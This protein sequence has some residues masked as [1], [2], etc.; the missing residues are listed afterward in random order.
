MTRRRP[1]RDSR[2]CVAEALEFR[3][4][5]SV[6]PDASGYFADESAPLDIDL[7]PGD[8]GVITL[9]DHT[10]DGYAPLD[11]LGNTFRF[12]GKTY[13][14][15]Q[16]LW[17]S[18]NGVI[19]FDAP[20]YTF[21]NADLGYAPYQPAVAP[22]WDE[23]ITYAHDL[24]QVIYRFDN[25]DADPEP[26][27]LVVEWNDVQH[28]YAYP[29]GNGVTFQAILQLNTG[30]T[31]GEITFNYP[32]LDTG[33]FYSE[34]NDATAGIKGE[35]FDYANRL[36]IHY[37]TNLP[38]Q[39]VGTGKAVTITNI[40]NEAPEV[41]IGP[42]GGGNYTVATNLVVQL[43][44][45]GT[46]DRE[47]PSYSL[48]YEWDL[49]NDG[50]FGEYAWWGGGGGQ[51]GFELGNFTEF[52]PRDLPIGPHPIVLR[53][54]DG[55]G[56]STTV[57]GTIDVTINHAPVPNAGPRIGEA[58]NV[59]VG[60][61]AQLDGTLT[62][63]PDGPYESLW[64][65]WNLDGDED[66]GE[67]WYLGGHGEEIGPFPVYLANELQ[68][69]DERTITLRVTDSAGNQAY[70]DAVVRV[71]ANQAPVADAGPVGGGTYKVAPGKYIFLD[72]NNSRDPDEWLDSWTAF[73]WDFDNDLVFG[74]YDTVHGSEIGSTPYFVPAPGDPVGTQYPVALQVTDAGG[75]TSTDTAVV[76]IVPN[77]PPVADAGP[78]NPNDI[79]WTQIGGQVYLNGG[80]STDFEDGY[81]EWPNFQWD[82]DNDGIFGE[83]WYNGGFPENGDEVGPDV[84]LDTWNLGGPREYTVKLRVYDFDGLYGEDEATVYITSGPFARIFNPVKSSI[85]GSMIALDGFAD[86]WTGVTP[87]SYSWTV[88]KDGQPY[89]E[90]DQQLL[91][92]TPQ[93]EGSF[94]VSLR[95]TDSYGN[96]SSPTP[97]TEL[98][99]NVG[100]AAPQVLDYSATPGVE[101][102]E[103]T[104]T[105]TYFDFGNGDRHTLTVDWGDGTTEQVDLGV[106]GPTR[107][108][109]APTEY[110]GHTYFAILGGQ[111]SWEQAEAEAQRIGGHLVAINDAAENA[112]VT[113]FVRQRYGGDV[114]AWIGLNDHAQEGRFVW[115]SGESSTYRNWGPGEPNNAAVHPDGEDYVHLN[116]PTPGKWNDL[117]NEGTGG[118]RVY[119]AVVEIN[120]PAPATPPAGPGF[121]VTHR[122][123]DNG[124]YDI[125]F[126][127]TDD[128]G[129]VAPAARGLVQW[130]DGPGANGHYYRLTDALATFPDAEAQAA[131]LGGHLA[132]V[133]SAD[134]QHFLES[135]FLTGV[136]P[137]PVYW[138]GFTDADNYSFEGS[139]VWTSGEPVTY[140]NWY[141][142]TREPNNSGN[143]DYTTL[144]FFNG[145]AD[146]FGSWN[147]IGAPGNNVRYVGLMEFATLPAGMRVGH[148]VSVHVANA[149]PAIATASTSASDPGAA[150]APGSAVTLSAS[151]ADAGILDTHTAVIDW[152]DGNTSDGVVDEAGGAGSVAGSH[153]YAQGGI[154]SVTLTVTDDDGASD[155]RSLTVYVS[156]SRLHNGELQIVGTAGADQVAIKKVGGTIVVEGNL[157]GVSPAA[158]V[159]RI[160]VLLG[161]GNDVVTVDGSVTAPLAVLAGGGN[162]Q[163]KGG[164]GT[165]VLV[166]GDGDDALVGGT[167]RDLLIGGAGAD[168]LNGNAGDDILVAGRTAH[169][170][171]LAALRALIADWAGAGTLQER[172]TRLTGGV[173]PGGF[174]LSASTVWDDA[175]SDVLTGTA[176][177]DWFAVSSAGRKQI[178]DLTAADVVLEVSQAQ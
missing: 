130:T 87:F 66:F 99:I 61:S 44:A 132:S 111:L 28:Y 175:A 1:E 173:G 47:Q 80:R 154:Y 24:D 25:T 69:G 79:Y 178:T 172:I 37:Y 171:D 4:L 102:G 71:V 49:D 89:L 62:T 138:I 88:T 155:S 22:L 8:P 93:D 76:E 90:S 27:R 16:A 92:F 43:D 39:G 3:R 57:H 101:G 38:P 51:N 161:D 17:V 112:F 12:Y 124:D 131:A 98:D 32:D 157:A 82:L 146:G 147:D 140:T 137:Q 156:G 40:G 60:R 18:T 23:W 2:H 63:D 84:F 10:I 36:L 128:D 65:D 133:N 72:G 91:R 83:A 11:L 148:G 125:S 123:G 14:G 19:T 6:G 13:T 29:S 15:S 100:N 53:V 142:P 122:Y 94:H 35:G 50:E 64:W 134:E 176:G 67:P 55:G 109:S 114:Y 74:E 166:G 160:L 152:G 42:P 153:V 139:F 144:N 105:G 21:G 41:N 174:A 86:P 141:L 52:Q 56:E 81:I 96:Q 149:A 117:P 75:L 30:D 177:G 163:L 33:D 97:L 73:Q 103:V 151:F 116:W 110:G 145:N 115:A 5:L 9:L 59:V 34:G 31:P 77:R 108:V 54:T 48:F 162:D 126:D 167:G 120:G 26:D 129:A 70:D 150:A 104:L 58:Y 106:I 159:Q 143:E 169:D 127:L 85:E 107:P 170:A 165:N 168:R 7:V 118:F 113:D 121:R 158:G 135:N 68:V 45:S 136:F 164:N 119:A 95:V 78:L 20:D 46:T